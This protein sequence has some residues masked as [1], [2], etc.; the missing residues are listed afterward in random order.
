MFLINQNVNS[1][2]K[3][4]GRRLSAFLEARSQ[5]AGRKLTIIDVGGQEIFWDNVS[6]DCVERIDLVNLTESELD[7]SST[8]GSGV[9][10]R[11]LIGNG[12]ALT[13]IADKAYDVCHSNSVV[14]HVGLWRD[15]ENFTAEAR[16]VA[17]AGWMQ[18]PAWEF[19]IEPHLRQPFIH[20]FSRPIQRKFMN[21]PAWMPNPTANERRIYIEDFNLLSRVEF[22]ALMPDADLWTERLAMLPKSYVLSWVCEAS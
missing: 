2:R 8:T 4:R 9:E 19:P 7:S 17:D 3:A 11:R 5:A 16:R 1:F 20:W 22:Q 18:T 21:K 12:C 14:E 15:M 10:F 13:Q 6:L